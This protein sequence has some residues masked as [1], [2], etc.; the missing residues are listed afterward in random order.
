MGLSGLLDTHDSWKLME[1]TFVQSFSSPSTAS[2]Y[3]PPHAHHVLFSSAS[4]FRPKF[5]RQCALAARVSLRV[6]PCNMT[7]EQWEAT[8]GVI[9][10]GIKITHSLC[11]TRDDLVGP[12][13]GSESLMHSSMTPYL[14]SKHY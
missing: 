3:H 14:H 10:L 11:N 8:A 1:E 5:F 2:C 4:S 12:Y 13:C 7:G 6:S 9:M